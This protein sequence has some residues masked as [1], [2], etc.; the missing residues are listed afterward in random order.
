VAEPLNFKIATL[1]E[2]RH[3]SPRALSKV[4]GDYIADYTPPDA[5]IIYDV[6]GARTD[7][8][9]EAAGPREMNYF[10]GEDVP[11]LLS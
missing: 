2:P 6:S 8:F 7:L 5:R 10:R 4:A 3:L 1:G 9:F 11:P